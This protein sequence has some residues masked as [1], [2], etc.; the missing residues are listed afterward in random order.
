M[1]ENLVST[2]I[3]LIITFPIVLL[4]R[5][6]NQNL[7]K[8]I[9]LVILYHLAYV[10]LVFLPIEYP[11]LSIQAG[12]MNW[13]GKI[14]AFVFSVAF[15]FMVKSRIS[16]HDYIF[17]MLSKAKL[18]KVTVVGVITLV[19]M[20]LLTILF[21]KA[22]PFNMEKLVYQ[23]TIPGLDEEL[24]RGILIGVLMILM[25]DGKFKFGHPAVWV[26]TIIFALG[27]SLY[28]QDW[29]LGFALD[30]FI[31]TGALGFILGWM[32]LKTRS[33]LPALVFH[34][35][36]NFSSNILEMAIL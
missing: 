13:T 25:K 36:I 21:S 4:Y 15:Y 33:I 28:F 8:I 35:L 32:T 22:K 26:A 6:S 2:L 7:L 10:S 24:W 9:G 1:A 34:N 18:K 11:S 17:S 30:A 31:I 16:D 29:E 27:H 3:G 23:F 19:V 20:C 12:S 14:L 5:G